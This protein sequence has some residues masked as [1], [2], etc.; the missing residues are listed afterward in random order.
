MKLPSR[1]GFGTEMHPMKK[2][3]II[4]PSVPPLAR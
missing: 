2:V 4:F 3:A 1:A